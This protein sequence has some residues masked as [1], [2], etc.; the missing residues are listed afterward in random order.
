MIQILQFIG[1]LSLMVILHEFGHFIAAKAFGVRVEKFYLFFNPGFSLFKYKPKNSETEYG[2]GWLPFGGYVK[3]AGMIDE[4]LDTKQMAGAVQPWEFRA[5][6]AWQRLIIMA[7]GVLM[8][9]LTAVV[10]SAM[11]LF[12]YGKQ[13]VSL[14]DARFGMEFSQVAQAHGFVNGDVLLQA[15]GQQLVEFNMETMRSM[16]NAHEITVLRAGDTVAIPIDES[17]KLDLLE[18]ETGFA[19]FRFPFVIKHVMDMTPAQMAGLQAGDSVVAIN[20]IVVPTHQDANVVLKAN[21]LQPISIEYSRNGQLCTT[22]ATLDSAGML[23]VHLTPYFELLPTT[24]ITYGFFE[25]IPL[26]LAESVGMFKGYADDIKVVFTPQGASSVGGFGSLAGL[27]PNAFSAQYF[28]T[29]IGYLSIILAFMNL[30]PIPG[31]DGGHILFLI[32]E[33]IRRKPLSQGFMIK[34]QT[35]GMILLFA[36][37]IYANGMDLF[38]WLK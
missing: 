18:E 25:S 8:N 14:S 35:I 3:L 37:L 22:T 26:G 17:L 21:K 7:G 12:S 5:K 10:V 4:S 11:L 2:I 29:I 28:W 16:L 27:F 33:C 19:S 15:D 38:R 13:Y 31:L 1:A 36:L 20:G 6:P 24:K 23:G 9:F 34:A 32:I 30:L